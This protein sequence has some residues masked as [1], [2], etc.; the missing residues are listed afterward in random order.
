MNKYVVK[1][2][3]IRIYEIVAD[4][5]EEAVSIVEDCFLPVEPDITIENVEKVVDK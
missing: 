3:F 5:E 2:E 4:T 1:V